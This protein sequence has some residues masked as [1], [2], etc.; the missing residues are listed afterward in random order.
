MLAMNGSTL[1][2]DEVVNKI[3]GNRRLKRRFPLKLLA[4]YKVVRSRL[5]PVTGTGMTVDV[6][7]GGVSFTADE[8]F[9]MGTH[10]ELSVN[11]P[12]LLNGDCPIRLVIEG[13]VVR[14][15]HLL[16]ALQMDRHEF[17]TQGRSQIHAASPDNGVWIRAAAKY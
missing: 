12:V 17:R 8:T 10:I 13:R 4:T 3:S 5:L 6:S 9:S 14:S 7:S 15:T 2:K 11:W 16:T 1:T